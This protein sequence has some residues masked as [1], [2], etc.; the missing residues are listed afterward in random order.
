MLRSRASP[1]WVEG[2]EREET[3][4]S[5]IQPFFTKYLLARV[6]SRWFQKALSRGPTSYRPPP[7]RGWG[8][9][10][11]SMGP[12]GIRVK[13]GGLTAGPKVGHL[14]VGTSE[15]PGQVCHGR[16]SRMEKAL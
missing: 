2:Q 13:R 12:Q 11:R 14:V 16:G 1:C 3:A 10:R 4:Q 5:Y 9:L 15:S 6:L 7:R 8:V